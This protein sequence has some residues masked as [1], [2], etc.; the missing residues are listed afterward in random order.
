MA[1]RLRNVRVEDDLWAAA[2]AAA[3]RR[4]TNRSAYVVAKLTEL[5]EHDKAQQA[6]VNGLTATPATDQE[7]PR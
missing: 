4:G 2:E 7:R 6:F 5:V 1:T 3:A